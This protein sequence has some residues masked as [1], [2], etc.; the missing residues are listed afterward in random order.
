MATTVKKHTLLS[1]LSGKLPETTIDVQG[2]R[3]TLRLLRPEGEDWVAMKTEGTTMTAV[4]GNSRNPTLAVSLT[5]INETPV[6]Q[7]FQLPDDMDPKTKELLLSSPSD[8]REWRRTQVLEWIREEMDPF[9]VK[10]LYEAYRELSK[11][12]QESLKGISSFSNRTPS[13]G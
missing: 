1:E 4:L 5:S 9:V 7:L 13:V 10:A 2:V 11:Q 3:Y 12:H 8:L 6:E